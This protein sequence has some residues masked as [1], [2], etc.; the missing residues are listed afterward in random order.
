MNTNE[1]VP[2]TDSQMEKESTTIINNTTEETSDNETITQMEDKEITTTSTESSL[3]ISLP[4]EKKQD[5]EIKLKIML[6]PV[7]NSMAYQQRPSCGCSLT[8]PLPPNINS[9][10]PFIPP[11]IPSYQ[12][13][14]SLNYW[15]PT[16][17]P[18]NLN[19]NPK[20]LN[21]LN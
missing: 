5:L 12:Q 6:M 10:I 19:Q 7:Y 8:P 20:R 18:C 3:T 21:F 11:P 2:Q 17:S 13:S 16:V 14:S 15:T 4:A 1:I 9:L